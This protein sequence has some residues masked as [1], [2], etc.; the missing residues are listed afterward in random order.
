MSETATQTEDASTPRESDS[1]GEPLLAVDD[2]KTYFFTDEGT[3]RA[4]DGVSFDIHPGE[5]LGIVGESGS[6]K[7]VT[8]I[9]IIGLIPSPPGE[10]VGGE[11]R[12]K[13]ENL[14]EKSDREMRKIRGNEISM[15]WQDPMSSLNPFLRISTQLYEPLKLH[16]GLSESEA[17]ERAIDMLE[18]VG[19]PGASERIDQYPHQFSG[20][21]R[22]RVM[23]AMALLCEPDLLI[24]DE[25][26]TALDVTIQAQILE[27]IKELREDFGTS[28]ITITHDLGVVAGVADRII[29][30]YAGR[31]MEEAPANELFY[32]PSH[33]YTVGLLKSVPR[34]DR[35]GEE[36]LIPIEGRPPDTSKEI[37]GCPFAERCRWKIEK[38]EDEFPPPVDFGHQHRSYCWRAE[39]VHEAELGTKT[40]PKRMKEIERRVLAGETIEAYEEDGGDDE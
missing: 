39:E 15:I 21:M 28:V 18:K 10:I 29:V 31:V 38:C 12:F 32:R 26:T 36:E 9:S 7:S 4:V 33:P 22:Q 2:L 6:G 11:V 35:G 1:R 14:F 30:M 20:G 17:R 19:I 25:P 24:A 16:Q 8:Q 34:L 40:S 37:K 3:I 13:G 5:S 23:I 27:L